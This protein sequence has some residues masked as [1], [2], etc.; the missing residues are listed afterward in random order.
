M[1]ADSPISMVNA[2]ARESLSLNPSTVSIPTE[3][4]GLPSNAGSLRV[5][6]N[7]LFSSSRKNLERSTGSL[8]NR[9]TTA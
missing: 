9:A 6:N 7:P 5:R 3:I 4:E 2:A 8:L 1:E